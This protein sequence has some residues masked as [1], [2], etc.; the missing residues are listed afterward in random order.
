[1]TCTQSHDPDRVKQRETEAETGR[2][3]RRAMA[4]MRAAVLVM[5]LMLN[6]ANG[7]FSIPKVSCLIINLEYINCMWL[8]QG[9]PEFNYTFHSRHSQREAYRECPVYLVR[10]GRAVGCRLLYEKG[11]KFR[12]LRTRLTTNSSSSERQQEIDLQ[13]LG[14]CRIM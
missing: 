11:I 2:D 8:E 6:G 13:D 10:D 1:M 14:E 5:A 7:D 9:I 4:E 3:G 12:R